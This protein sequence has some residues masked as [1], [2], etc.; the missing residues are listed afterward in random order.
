M[1]ARFAAAPILLALAAPAPAEVHLRLSPVLR[2]GGAVASDLF[3]GAGVGPGA[4]V[5]LAPS[6]AA[7]L[8]LATRLKL[9]TEYD[10]AYAYTQA[11]AGSSWDHLAS[12]AVRARIW[13][14][15]WFEP[16]GRFGSERYSEVGVPDDLVVGRRL[17][18]FDLVAAQP[19]L[20]WR[21][22]RF[23][24]GLAYAWLASSSLGVDGERAV[25]FAEM[26]PVDS[27]EGRAELWR[28]FKR[29]GVSGALRRAGAR[30]GDRVRLGEVEL[31]IEG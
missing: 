7:D 3:L 11:N 26:M 6:L 10:F 12:L 18:A 19:H 20:R 23:D 2:S 28:R 16:S 1:S 31:E 9:R 13:D 5:V 17:R 25:A 30:A 22:D 21:G 8:S 27:E 29:W 14:R 24:F 15:L 4:E